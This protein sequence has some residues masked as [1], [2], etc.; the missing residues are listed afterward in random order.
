[1]PAVCKR[2]SLPSRRPID[3]LGRSKVSNFGGL[4][5]SLIEIRI[6]AQRETN[7]PLAPKSTGD[8]RT[9]DHPTGRPAS[10]FLAQ[11]VCFRDERRVSDMI[12]PS[13]RRLR[14]AR[15]AGLRPRSPLWSLAVVASL[16]AMLLGWLGPRAVGWLGVALEHA[17]AGE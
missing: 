8:R 16:G 10:L 11:V 6:M 14:D 15:A 1:M 3:T 5:S 4:P 12:P 17:V 2:R 9:P 13:Q 7:P